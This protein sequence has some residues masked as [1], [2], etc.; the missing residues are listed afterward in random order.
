MLVKVGELPSFEFFHVYSLNFIFLGQERQ[1]LLGK[2]TW[3][4]PSVPGASLIPLSV[5]QGSRTG[6]FEWR[7]ELLAQ[8]ESRRPYGRGQPGRSMLERQTSGRVHGRIAELP[9]TY[10]EELQPFGLGQRR[11]GEL[12][13]TYIEEP[14]PFG[15]GQRRIA[16][17]PDTCRWELQPFGLGQRRIRELPDTCIDELQPSGLGQRRIGELPDTCIEELQLFGLGPPGGHKLELQPSGLVHGRTGEL[18][19]KCSS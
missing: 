7:M 18:P 17:L 12:P 15:L 16:E 13:D 6:P 9:D 4:R 8:G 10:I 19:D 2:H 5:L 1:G 14:Q 11:F 3:G